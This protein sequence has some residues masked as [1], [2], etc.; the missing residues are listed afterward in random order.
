M[1]KV[2]MLFAQNTYCEIPIVKPRINRKL[3]NATIPMILSLVSFTSVS[4]AMNV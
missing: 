4:I 1:I 3:N 2:K